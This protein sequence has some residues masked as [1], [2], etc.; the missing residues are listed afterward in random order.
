MKIYVLGV[1]K[2]SCCPKSLW[3]QLVVC[4]ALVR[5]S[6][7]EKNGQIGVQ[8]VDSV[9]RLFQ[10]T[11]RTTPLYILLRLIGDVHSGRRP[12]K[13]MLLPSLNKIWVLAWPTRTLSAAILARQL[14]LFVWAVT[15]VQDS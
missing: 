10:K 9:L 5:E 2:R 7:K 13:Q 11:P 1:V 4:G 8:V 15:T 6:T 14:S 12:T 3:H